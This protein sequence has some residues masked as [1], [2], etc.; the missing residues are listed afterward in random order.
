[1]AKGLTF[2]L[3]ENDLMSNSIVQYNNLREEVMNTETP[4]IDEQVEQINNMDNFVAISYEYDENYKKK[5]LD[6]I[7]DYYSISKRKKRKADLIQDIVLF[8][9]NP[10]NNDIVQ[11]RKTL[12]FYMDE[13]LN[14]DFLKKYIILD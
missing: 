8:E 5:E 10:L 9:I 7:A 12:W 2:T 1:M 4:E 13:I 6:R 3:I 14:D 11:K